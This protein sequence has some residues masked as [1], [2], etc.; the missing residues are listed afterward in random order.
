MKLKNLT[1]REKIDNKRQHFTHP[2]PV[3]CDLLQLRTKEGTRGYII[4]QFSFELITI[5]K[6]FLMQIENKN[7][8]SALLYHNQSSG[9]IVSGD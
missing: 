2:K 3:I 9:L 6:S 5:S 8:P 1:Q 7:T 4:C